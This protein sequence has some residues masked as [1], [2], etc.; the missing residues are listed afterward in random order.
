MYTLAQPLRTENNKQ[1]KGT[2]GEG[3]E[4]VKVDRI[5]G[6]SAYKLKMRIAGSYVILK[7]EIIK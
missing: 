1:G 4:G 7:I 5:A 2:I 6:W 3:S